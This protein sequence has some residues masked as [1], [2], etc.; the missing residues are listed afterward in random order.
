METCWFE[1]F[2]AQ[3]CIDFT[4]LPGFL[5]FAKYRLVDMYMSVTVASVKEQIVK[6]F[7]DPSDNLRTCYIYVLLPLAILP[8]I[9]HWG[10]SADLYSRVWH[11]WT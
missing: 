1:E 2:K 10:P 5:D 11:G 7:C 8:I 3:L 4:S 6:S 9:V